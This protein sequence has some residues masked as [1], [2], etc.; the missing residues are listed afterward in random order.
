MTTIIAHITIKEGS[1][2][3]FDSIM[4]DV[5]ARSRAEASGV[6]RYEYF[7]GQATNF[8]YCLRCFSDKW[9]FYDHQSSDHHEGH[10]FGAVVDHIHLED[11]DP[12][13]NANPL[14]KTVDAPLESHHD[15]RLRRAAALYPLTIAGWWAGRR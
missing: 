14:P 2:A 12:V 11:V 6:L 10:D 3:Q 13:S 5:V 15:E 1:E 9:A 7:K 8:Y 4:E